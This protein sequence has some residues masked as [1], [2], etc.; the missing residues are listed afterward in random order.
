[1]KTLSYFFNKAI[2]SSRKGKFYYRP[3]KQVLLILWL[4]IK[5]LFLTGRTI[6]EINFGEWHPW[7]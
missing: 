5:C 6:D 1:M 4:N 3:W 2:W 7:G